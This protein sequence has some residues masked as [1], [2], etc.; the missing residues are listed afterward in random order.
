MKND[1][2]NTLDHVITCL[3]DC[4]GHSY[5]Q[6]VQCATLTHG[7]KRCS[8][9]VDTYDSCVDVCEELFKLGLDTVI[10]KHKPYVN[11]DPKN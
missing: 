8:I 7:A 2:V 9:Y 3:I 5:Y 10:E 11:V 1:S 6:A 4:C